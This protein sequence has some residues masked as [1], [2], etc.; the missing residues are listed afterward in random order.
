M[1]SKKQP[2]RVMVVDDDPLIQAGIKGVLESDSS[3]F[4]VASAW[5]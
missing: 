2:V 1:S 4:V 5:T 3:I